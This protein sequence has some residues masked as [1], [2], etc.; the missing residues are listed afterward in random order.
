LVTGGLAFLILLLPITPLLD[1]IF[2]AGNWQEGVKAWPEY[3]RIPTLIIYWMIPL[4]LGQLLAVLLN[5]WHKTVYF[6][7]ALETFHMVTI[8]WTPELA[9]LWALP[10]LI[11]LGL[12]RLGWVAKAAEKGRAREAKHPTPFG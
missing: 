1:L 10:A 3:L 9:Y 11:A 8:L 5:G 7:A 12:T 4:A 2:G 6:A